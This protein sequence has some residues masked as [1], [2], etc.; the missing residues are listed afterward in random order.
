MNDKIVASRPEHVFFSTSLTF[1]PPLHLSAASSQIHVAATE[2]ATSSEWRMT[3]TSEGF[4]DHRSSGPDPLTTT[5][6]TSE[7]L[8]KFNEKT[9]QVVDVRPIALVSRLVRR[10]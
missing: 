8:R 7:I 6:V 5:R 2:L 4:D 3:T 10:R 1:V 9:F